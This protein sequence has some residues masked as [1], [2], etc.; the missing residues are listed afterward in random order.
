MSAAAKFDASTQ[1]RRALIAKVHIGAKELGLAGDSYRDLL[2]GVTGKDSAGDCSDAELGGVLDR[3]KALGWKPAQPKGRG[4]GGSRPADHPGALKARAMWISLYQLGAINDA[5]EAG[6]EAFARR[7]LGCSRLQ[8]AD[9]SLVYKLIEAEKAIA[10]RHGWNQSTE[11]L[12][13]HAVPVVLKRRLI[14]RLTQ[15]LRDTGLVPSD[16]S[17]R[18]AAFELAGIESE[19]LL[20]E[21]ASRLEQIAAAFG[22]ALR[23]ALPNDPE[24]I[25]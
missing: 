18:R 7:Q 20:L 3:L 19:T 16:W 8:W 12:A 1:R 6:L 17:P 23:G 14:E 10:E 15:K 9:Q 4:P 11:G 2:F 5:S 21:S 24:E 25:R 22:E 13:P